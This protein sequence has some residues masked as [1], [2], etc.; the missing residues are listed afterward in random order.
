MNTDLKRYELF[1]WDYE[2]HSPLSKREVAWYK[3]FAHRI[4]G[5]VL[6]LACGTGR[7]LILIA[8]EGY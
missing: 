5:P 4:G 6:E 2:H 8:K 1:G 7:L 3:R